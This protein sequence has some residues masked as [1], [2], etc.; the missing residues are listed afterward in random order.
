MSD[1]QT[2]PFTRP[3][4]RHSQ[5]AGDA[6]PPP[7]KLHWSLLLLF[8]VISF[9]V[10]QFVWMFVQSSWARKVD[11][12]SKATAFFAGDVFLFLL[13]L[14]FAAS[15]DSGFKSLEL[16]FLLGSCI[17][18]YAGVYSIRRTM[19]DHYNQ[20]EPM[21]LEMSGAMTLLFALLHLQYHMTRIAYAKADGK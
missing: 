6:F 20:I 18:F 13:S 10:F 16:P 7:P 3:V 5:S 12:E 9:G 4:A 1:F 15:S 17:V 21:Q 19:L 8:T 2:E 11:P 14:V